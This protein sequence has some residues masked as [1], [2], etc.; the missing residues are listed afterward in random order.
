MSSF[1]GPVSL[2]LIR[3]TMLN[4][5]KCFGRSQ[6]LIKAEANEN[7]IGVVF[8]EYSIGYMD[9]NL[10][11]GI[12]LASIV[13]L[14]L[15]RGQLPRRKPDIA[16]CDLR[17]FQPLPSLDIGA[18][19]ASSPIESRTDSFHISSHSHHGSSGW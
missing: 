11:Y 1:R 17:G 8:F 14:V 6:A 2:D 18:K 3:V 10:E 4:H 9:A 12:I 13:Q 16:C 5:N 19:F 7:L 15:L